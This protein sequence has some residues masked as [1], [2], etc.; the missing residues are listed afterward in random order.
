MQR[1]KIS[2]SSLSFLQAQ[3]KTMKPAQGMGE[4]MI[5]NHMAHSDACPGGCSG[6]HT[7][8]SNSCAGYAR[9]TWTRSRNAAAPM[10]QLSL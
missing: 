6:Y 1:L 4:E 3:A 9:G 7:G 2:Q 5:K 10:P 8:C